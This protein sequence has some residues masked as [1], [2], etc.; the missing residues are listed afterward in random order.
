MAA[1]QNCVSQA[2]GLA[3]WL[4]QRKPNDGS[5]SFAVDQYRLVLHCLSQAICAPQQANLA[6]IMESGYQNCDLLTTY[7]ERQKQFFNLLPI[8]FCILPALGKF[9]LKLCVLP[10]PICTKLTT[11]S[12]I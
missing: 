11:F 3:E 8:L 7:V 10:I 12:I 5:G 1:L 6:P 2:L 9:D 4:L